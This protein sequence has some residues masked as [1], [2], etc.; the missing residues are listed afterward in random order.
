MDPFLPMTEAMTIPPRER[1]RV[2][3]C[4]KSVWRRW[5]DKRVNIA[6]D[7]GGSYAEISQQNKGSNSHPLP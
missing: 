2:I 4:V 7:P 5:R 1:V 3:L 6:D